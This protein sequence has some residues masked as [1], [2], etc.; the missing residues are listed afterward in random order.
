MPHTIRRPA[1]R[2][3][4]RALI[5]AVAAALVLPAAA[6]AC[7][8]ATGGSP[9]F[10]QF[11]DAADYTLLRGG[12]FEDVTNGWSFAGAAVVLGNESFGLHGASDSHSLLIN[13]SGAAV[14]PTICVDTSTPSFR[15][16]SRR[17]SG[18][19]AQM[20]VNLLW[21]DS[22]GMQHTTTA[23]SLG[24]SAGW[25]PSPVLA[26]GSSLPLWQPGTTLDVRL[27]FLPA[28]YGGAWAIDD[29]YLDP[30]SR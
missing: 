25:Q 19:W 23:G 21:T 15:F 26:L 16:V 7:T 8:P 10:A 4:A 24:G 11:G 14:S 22:T 3:S 29:I 6:H 9:V 13:P 28:R 2:R 1:V 17:A 27:Q 30:Y 20:T 18:S 5:C 12:S